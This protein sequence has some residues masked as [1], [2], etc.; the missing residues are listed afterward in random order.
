M[1]IADLHRDLVR[2]SF[3]PTS[4]VT[5][6]QT[7]AFCLLLAEPSTALKRVPKKTPRGTD[8]RVL[9]LAL[10]LHIRLTR[11]GWPGSHGDDEDEGSRQLSA[12]FATLELPDLLWAIVCDL[13]EFWWSMV[14]S[15]PNDDAA[16][17][18]ECQRQSVRLALEW[19]ASMRKFV[20]SLGG[21]HSI[22]IF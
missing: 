1:S 8:P 3:G 10:Q 14:W 12:I 20:N 18:L 5:G 16:E 2:E 15:W 17:T 13:L 6:E 22:L 7:S 19:P 11:C 21:A 4:K 9:I